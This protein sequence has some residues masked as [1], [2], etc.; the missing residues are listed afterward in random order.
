[1]VKV[2]NHKTKYLGVRAGN[3]WKRSEYLYEDQF[4]CMSTKHW[5]VVVKSRGVTP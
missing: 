3:E 1:M 4:Q 5:Q 2:G